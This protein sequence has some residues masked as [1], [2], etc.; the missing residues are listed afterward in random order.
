MDARLLFPSKYLKAVEFKGR[1][2]TLTVTSVSL[3]KLAAEDGSV[4]EKGIVT[5]KE[6]KKA[7]VLNRTNAQCLIA[8]WGYET[9][10]WVGKRVTLFPATV[11]AFGAEE[12]AI[13]VRGSPDLKK[14]MPIEI[15]LP[16]KKPI[17][18]VLRKTGG[19]GK[20]TAPAPEPEANPDTGEVPFSDEEQEQIAAQES[21]AAGP[22]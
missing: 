16:R 5:F 22:F 3:E 11:Q 7:L 1:D 4:K 12:L 15:N 19:N 20:K 6:T 13:R 10:Q 9:D 8:L 14:D 21:A 18:A 17:R 2:A